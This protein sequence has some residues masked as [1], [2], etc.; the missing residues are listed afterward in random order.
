M[1]R[2]MSPDGT[3]GM[4]PEAQVPQALE[5]GARVID[6]GAMRELR[7]AVFMQ[8]TLFKDKQAAARKQYQSPRYSRMRVR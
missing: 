4:I 3:L 2:M 1:I 6:S 8:H 5:A 7:Q